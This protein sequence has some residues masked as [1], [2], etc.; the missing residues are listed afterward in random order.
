MVCSPLCAEA[1]RS[2]RLSLTPFPQLHLRDAGDIINHNRTK[3]IWTMVNDVTGITVNGQK[4]EEP[5]AV[6]MLWRK[7]KLCGERGK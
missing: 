7:D 4:V 5:R 2:Q 1:P 6:E 3:A